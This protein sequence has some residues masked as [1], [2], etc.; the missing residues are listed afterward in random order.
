MPRS[1]NE[2]VA[3]TLSGQKNA[4]TDKMKRPRAVHLCF[5]QV[6]RA[7]RLISSLMAQV[8]KDCKI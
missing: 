4:T 7:D 2:T 1:T 5:F 3:E 8:L 6:C